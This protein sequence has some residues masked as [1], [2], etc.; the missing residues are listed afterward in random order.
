MNINSFISN[1][2]DTGQNFSKLSNV[3]FTKN[4]TIYNELLRMN[5]LNLYK[6]KLKL[7]KD[8]ILFKFIYKLGNDLLE[9]L[10]NHINKSKN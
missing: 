6:F 3:Y 2:I 4:K 9:D 5:G 7:A 10:L 8:N 1:K